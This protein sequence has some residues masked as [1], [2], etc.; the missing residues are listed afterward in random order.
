MRSE[1]Y[2][3]PFLYCVTIHSIRV[4]KL[5]WNR[6]WRRGEYKVSVHDNVRKEYGKIALELYGESVLTETISPENMSENVGYTFEE[7]AMAPEGA[8]M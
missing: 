8:N 2:L 1:R 5:G 4:I 3:H 7:L 6:S